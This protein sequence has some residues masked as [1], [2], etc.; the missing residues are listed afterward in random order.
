[1]A[2]KGDTALA[3]AV[4]PA[5][6]VTKEGFSAVAEE[7]CQITLDNSKKFAGATDGELVLNSRSGKSE[8]VTARNSAVV[9]C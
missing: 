9:S 3:G 4:S 1:V 2:I 8:G 6:T 5:P 7:L